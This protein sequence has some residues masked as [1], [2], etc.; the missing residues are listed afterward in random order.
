MCCHHKHGYGCPW[1][2]LFLLKPGIFRGD[3]RRW[4]QEAFVFVLQSLPEALPSVFP[5]ECHPRN[6]AQPMGYEGHVCVYL[7]TALSLAWLFL[8]FASHPHQGLFAFLLCMYPN[9]PPTPASASQRLVLQACSLMLGTWVVLF[10]LWTG[11]MA[12]SWSWA[13]LIHPCH[14]TCFSRAEAGLFPWALCCGSHVTA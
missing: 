6:Q 2:V 12:L 11:P 1:C 5:G 3:W 7:A 10:P 9:W 4:H 13:W 8:S 14:S